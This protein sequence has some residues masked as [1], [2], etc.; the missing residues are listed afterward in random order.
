MIV[1][2]EGNGGDK[3]REGK[4]L[5]YFWKTVNGLKRSVNMKILGE[6]F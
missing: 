4:V 1:K 6:I 5:N 2:G 3:R